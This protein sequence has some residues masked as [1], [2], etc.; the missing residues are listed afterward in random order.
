MVDGLRLRERLRPYLMEQTRIARETG[1]PPMLPLLVDFPTDEASW[2]VSDEFLLGPDVLAAPI[3]GLRER[4]G[5]G[6][7]GSLL[8][9][10]SG[11]PMAAWNR[12]LEWSRPAAETCSRGLA[13]GPQA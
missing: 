4:D 11:F 9:D 10:G 12:E 5:A 8:G 13:P 1:L 3:T 6:F 7:W 2:A